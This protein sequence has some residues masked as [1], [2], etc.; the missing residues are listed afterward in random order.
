MDKYQI[1]SIIYLVLCC[2]WHSTIASINMDTNLKIYIDQIALCVFALLFAAIQVVT[3]IT[4]LISYKKLD[5]YKRKEQNFMKFVSTEDSDD[6]AL[7]VTHTRS[8]N[9][10]LVFRLLDELSWMFIYLFIFSK[11]LN[12][13]ISLIFFSF[14]LLL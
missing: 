12:M 5:E 1:I 13:A 9:K 14:A 4:I 6:E 7:W 8:Y 10:F 3:I 2:I 11:C